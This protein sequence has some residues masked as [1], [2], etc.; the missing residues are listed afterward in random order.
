MST[1]KSISLLILEISKAIGTYLKEGR[2]SRNKVRRVAENMISR[3]LVLFRYSFG[4][5]SAKGSGSLPLPAFQTI[6][7][8]MTLGQR[9]LRELV[10]PP[11]LPSTYSGDMGKD[12]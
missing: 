11:L 1:G 4:G 10:P 3:A 7:K 12:L 6:P 9:D 8:G 5:L 2:G